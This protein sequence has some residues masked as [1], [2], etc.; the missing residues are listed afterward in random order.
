MV[1]RHLH[2]TIRLTRVVLSLG[3][4]TSLSISRSKYLFVSRKILFVV[5]L[6]KEFMEF[7]VLTVY[8][9]IKIV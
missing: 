8:I 5:Y 9:D 6:S 1:Q 3:V 7:T 4:G 2:K